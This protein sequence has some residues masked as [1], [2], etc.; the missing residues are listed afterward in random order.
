MDPEQIKN[1]RKRVTKGKNADDKDLGQLNLK[2]KNW[3]LFLEFVSL[4]IKMSEFG[5]IYE[6]ESAAY[7]LGALFSDIGG[8][9]GL[10]LGLSILDLFACS[11]LGFRH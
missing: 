11:S 2:P 10:V 6:R 8:A 1:F 9:L 4:S 5:G 3:T 7:P